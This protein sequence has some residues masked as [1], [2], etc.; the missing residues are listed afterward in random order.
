MKLKKVHFLPERIAVQIKPEPNWAC[1]SITLPNTKANLKEGW[2]ALLR[3]QF[4]DIGG[5]YG[6]EAD[7]D[8]VRMSDE[9]A[10]S[11]IDF[12]DKISA[13]ETTEY[14]IVHC[15]AGISRSAAVALFA[16]EYYTEFRYDLLGAD[17]HNQFVRHKLE[18]AYYR[19]YDE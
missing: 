2:S 16:H 14:L 15:Q 4:H 13:D 12:L 11:V 10:D 1:I 3:L 9:Q 18:W 6:N 8:L 5:N 19:K 17:R 7:K